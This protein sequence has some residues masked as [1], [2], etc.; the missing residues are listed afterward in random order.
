MEC[1]QHHKELEVPYLRE[2]IYILDFAVADS[3]KMV[4]LQN[5]IGASFSASI[6]VPPTNTHSTNY[7]IFIN[8]PVIDTVYSLNTDS[9]VENRKKYVGQKSHVMTF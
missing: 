6:S 9:V 8:H 4:V 7:T 1:R 3:R 2:I 5:G